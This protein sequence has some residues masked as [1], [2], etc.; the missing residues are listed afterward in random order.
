MVHLCGSHLQHLESFREMKELRA[1]QINDRA[2]HDLE[3]YY[4]GLREDQIIYLNPCDGM[5]VEKAVKITGGHR[6]VIA[7]GT[8]AVYRFDRGTES[9]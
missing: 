8:G 2:A 6:L 7:G 1:F 3:D 4:K 5:T 9:G